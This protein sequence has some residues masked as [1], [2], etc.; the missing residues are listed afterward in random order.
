MLASPL[1]LLLPLPTLLQRMTLSS[2]YAST[3]LTRT[4][5]QEGPWHTP[6]DTAAFTTGSLYTVTSPPQVD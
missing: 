4:G 2:A 6:R 3:M 1:A 5:I